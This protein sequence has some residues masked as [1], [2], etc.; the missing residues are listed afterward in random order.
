MNPDG[1]ARGHLRTN[2]CGANL[3]REWASTGDYEAPT[4]LRSPEVFHTLREMDATGVDAFVD[5]HGDEAMPYNFISGAEGCPNW[6]DR[7]MALQGL[8]VRAYERANPDMQSF[9]SYDPDEAGKANL[10]I[11]SNQVCARFDCLGVTLEMPYKDCKSNPDPAEGWSPARCAALGRSLVDAI[12][13]ARP[14]LRAEG[15][16]WQ[17]LP[18]QDAY[19]RPVQS[20][21]EGECA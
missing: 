11:C 6:G 3:N 10:A 4:L 5:V 14:Y 20:K 15:N 1:A 12:A 18:A 21:E 16:F 2:A 9:F 8:F 19:I 13:Y 7:M 17:S